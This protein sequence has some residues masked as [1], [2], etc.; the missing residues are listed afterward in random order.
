MRR[1]TAQVTGENVNPQQALEQNK[2]SPVTEAAAACPA[3][4]QTA[5]T[6]DEVPGHRRPRAK[7]KPRKPAKRSRVNAA[8]DDA[9]RPGALRVPSRMHH[10]Y[11]AFDSNLRAW[12]L[13]KPLWQYPLI[14]SWRRAYLLKAHNVNVPNQGRQDELTAD[15]YREKRWKPDPAALSLLSTRTTTHNGWPRCDARGGA[16]LY[17]AIWQTAGRQCGVSGR[18]LNSTLRR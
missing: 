13:S 6:A 7:A 3:P 11:A 4:Q 16:V 15:Q 17:Y 1:V 14:R 18:T 9:D 10:L 12:W 2:S 8:D 5:D